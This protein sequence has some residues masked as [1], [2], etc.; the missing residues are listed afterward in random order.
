[1]L[2]AAG[3][4]V[5]P[6]ARSA[7]AE[8]LDA[9][10]GS[11]AEAEALAAAQRLGVPVEV[12]GSKS[13]ASRAVA[14]PQGSL[15]L[16]SYAGPRWAQGRDGAWRQIDTTL[17][18][19]ERGVAPVATLAD[20]SFSTGGTGAAVRV[21]LAGG[22]ATMSWPGVLAE[23]RL[24]G[25]T[26]VY[27]SVL[28]D[29]DLRL[30]ALADGFTWVLVVKSAQAAM[31]P[32][33]TE[34]RFAL[35]TPGLS[36][37]SREEGGFEVV[38]AAGEVLLSS[39]NALM[40]D[41]TGTAPAARSATSRTSTDDAE[42]SDEV[43]L[44]PPDLARK[45]E[46]PT[47]VQGADLVVRPDLE[48]LR[49]EDTVFPVV[50]D[51]YTTINK[52][53]WGY[54]GSE[55]ATRS[56][57]IAR[58]GV[59]PTGDGTFRSFFA[60]N[61]STLAGK[62]IRSAKFLTELIHS[63]SCTATPVNLW[64]T[65]DLTVSGKQTWDG[66]NLALWIEQR[67]GNAHKPP[68]APSCDN[69]PQ[70]D[71]PM[72]FSS[73]NLKNDII[74]HRGDSNYTLA[75]SNRQSD[76][77]SESTSTWWK[78]FD[79]AQTKLTVEYNTNPNTPTAAQL[80]THA[81][82]TAPALPCVTGTSRPA[83]RADYPWLKATLTDPDGSNGGSLSGVFALQK[84]SSS[85]TWE[86][87]TGW[88]KTDTG[89]APGAKAEVQ[90][91]TK[92]AD[93]EVYRWQV[94][95]KDTLGGVSAQ[96]SPW[97]EFAVDYAGPQV[98]P[99][100]TAADGL[101]L[102]SPPLG[103]NQEDRGS[104]GYSGRFTFSA[105]GSQ[106]VYDYAY[107]VAGGPILYAKPPTL[108]GPV[109]V[110]VTPT[111]VGENVLT[112]YSRDQVGN[113]S[114]GSYDYAFRAGIASAP[115]VTWAMD[116]GTGTTLAPEADAGP[117][118]TLVNGVTWT[119][120]RVL[121]THERLGK[122]WAV[123]LDGVDDHALAPTV[124]LDTSRSYS[125]AAWV[126]PDADGLMEIAGS[127]GSATDSF[128]LRKWGDNRWVFTVVEQDVSTSAFTNIFGP[129]AVKG[130]WTHVA[131]VYDAAGG[132]MRLYINGKEVAAGTVPRTFNAGG[133]IT[134]GRE[135]WNSTNVAYW[136]GAIS[137]VR[138]WDRVI[139]P[140]LDLVDI[141]APTPVGQW[142]M[143]NPDE[144]AR[145]EADLSRYQRP[146]TL[147]ADPSAMWTEGY[148][149]TSGVTINGSPGSADTSV[150]VL[151]TDQ[152]WTVS[153][154]AKVTKAE[155]Q[156]ILAQDGSSR[157]AYYLMYD[158]YTNKW[159]ITMPSVDVGTAE[160]QFVLSTAPAQLDAWTHLVA[161]YDAAN[162]ELRLYVNG[163]LQG[164]RSNTVGWHGTQV[165]HVG[166]AINSFFLNGGTVDGVRMWQGL[167]SDAEITHLHSAA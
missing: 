153:A 149:Y 117:A 28:P 36:K 128:M 40:W 130:I 101:Y 69:D 8:P 144:T 17:R 99:T 136:N 125:V 62:N 80:S 88:P 65:A 63:W 152:S 37:R 118:A 164:V 71:L 35:E 87:V 148:N 115:K 151:R 131:G 23:P 95:T 58:V 140:D 100:V 135:R 70:P 147:T 155:H 120:S 98:T 18:R 46:L 114:N 145:Q 111:R 158:I 30:R 129:P 49:G 13:E 104:V 73:T 47:D 157:S 165:M 6:G 76:G 102:E 55:N 92:T 19:T 122:D 16:E 20:V 32:A 27:E 78:K 97:C 146:L 113:P 126:R 44:T 51:P 123:K 68:A 91:S 43:L 41:S 139:V 124:G 119:D 15:L 24:E 156:T 21:A 85:T 110:W 106:D 64:R 162:R 67:S 138:T 93:G 96:W 81:G 107:Q 150:P 163:V 137:E 12:A 1:M 25:D 52:L 53:R 83:V 84:Q 167:L 60:F 142:E 108:G 89:V 141:L 75:L 112:V 33:L 54:A 14:T 3:V 9:P 94:Q 45:A 42:P 29:V 121:G 10:S 39:G 86:T 103:T 38:D 143:D 31:N 127:P 161:R 74:A 109:T 79:P 61:L 56:D 26:A 134:L 2:L 66:P 132:A 4:A 166:R 105:N 48:L 57:G 77:T 11:N 72:E 7:Y 133:D 59:E 50:I 159:C 82:Y 90:L 154:W 22:E 160:W 116:E 34:L 5:I